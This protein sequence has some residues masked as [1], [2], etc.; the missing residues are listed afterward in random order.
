MT[1]TDVRKLLELYDLMK[2]HKQALLDFRTKN[3]MLSNTTYGNMS[4]DMHAK[5]RNIITIADNACEKSLKDLSHLLT[6]KKD[7]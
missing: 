2:A 4:S 3:Q 6:E 5:T 1:I 7:V